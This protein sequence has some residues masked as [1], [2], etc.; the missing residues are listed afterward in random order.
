M[1]GMTRSL[2]VLFRFD[3]FLDVVRVAVVRSTTV[4]EDDQINNFN[5]DFDHIDHI[6]I[7]IES[8]NNN[9][10]IDNFIDGDHDF[11]KFDFIIPDAMLMLN[12]LWPC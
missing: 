4:T 8:D 5:D 11:N 9:D 3:A 6:N 1:V 12:Y 7:D 10:N 2:T